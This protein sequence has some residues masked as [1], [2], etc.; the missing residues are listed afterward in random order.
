[1]MHIIVNYLI[2]VYESSPILT[3]ALTVVVKI[4]HF[5]PFALIVSFLR[6]NHIKMIGY[7]KFDL[8]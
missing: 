1:M 6:Y 5:C 3:S 2:I 4:D 7:R 8:I